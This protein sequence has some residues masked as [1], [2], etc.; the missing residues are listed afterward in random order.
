MG[1]GTAT[2]DVVPAA[3]ATAS[4]AADA[5]TPRTRLSYPRD[6]HPT[7]SS[8]LSRRHE[9]PGPIPTDLP[10]R[11]P[12]T[13]VSSPVHF[14]KPPK[15]APLIPDISTPTHTPPARAEPRPKRNP[16]ASLPLPALGAA[17]GP[18]PRTGRHDADVRARGLGVVDGRAGGARGR[19][20]AAGPRARRHDADH[21]P[22]RDGGLAA[23]E[24]RRQRCGGAGLSGQLAG[25]CQRQDTPASAFPV[26]KTAAAAAAQGRQ[27]E[28]NKSVVPTAPAPAPKSKRKHVTIVDVLGAHVM[29]PRHAGQ[30]AGGGPAA[31]GSQ[32]Q[33]V[34]GS[35]FEQ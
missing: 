21:R 34:V 10:N 23:R 30:A 2:R 28:N 7:P 18:R 5:G 8:I 29:A 19:R 25:A 12:A 27:Q 1:R 35:E 33:A 11:R 4:V 26:Q 15:H 16:T 32:E 22:G 13:L 31:T 3:G 24:R 9:N 6:I 14:R 17:D 20:L